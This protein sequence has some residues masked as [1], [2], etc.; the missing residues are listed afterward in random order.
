M[1]QPSNS[2]VHG[3]SCKGE[4][5]NN[6]KVYR[7]RANS[8]CY[9]CAGPVKY[10]ESLEEMQ[11]YKQEADLFVKKWKMET[12]VPS[13]LILFFLLYVAFSYSGANG[14]RAGQITF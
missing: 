1:R 3:L 11:A 2:F 4:K 12:K 13:E 7:Q 8:E 9:F 6:I 10:R 14:K 5:N